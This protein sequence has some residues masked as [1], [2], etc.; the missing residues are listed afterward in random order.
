MNPMT[1]RELLERLFNTLVRRNFIVGDEVS[2]RD[3][4]KRYQ[5]PPLTMHHRVAMQMTLAEYKA[6][7]NLLEEIVEHFNPANAVE[8]AEG[9]IREPA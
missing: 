4:V 3:M 9:E 7:G 2:T 8:P 1:D 6:L 5:Q